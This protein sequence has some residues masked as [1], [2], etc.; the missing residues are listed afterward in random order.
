MKKDCSK[1]ATQREKKG[2]LWSR[3]PS[4]AERFI[5]VGDGNKVAVEAIETFRLLLKTGFHLDFVE[6]F[7]ASSIRRNLIS[8]SILDKSGYTCSFGNNKF[9]LSYDSNVVGYGSLNDNL[10]ML[11]IECPYNKIMQVESHGTKRKLNENSA[12]LWHKRLGHISKQRIQRLMSDEFGGEGNIRSVV[13]DEETI[14]DNDQ[15]FVPI[16][17]PETDPEINNDVIPN[18]P[19]EQDNAEFLPQAPPIVQTQQPQGLPL[20]RSTRERKCPISDDYVI[21]LQEHEDDIGLTEDDPINFSQA[22]RIFIG[23]SR[24][25]GCFILETSWLIVCLAQFWAVPRNVLKKA[26]SPATQSSNLFGD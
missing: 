7:V 6:T 11:D 14:T 9:S 26:Y 25:L 8:I 3:P 2:C 17:V 23:I 21:F 1:Y 5:Y 4:D 24:E 13:F 18:I 15:V 16:V 10:Y 22:M 12:T 20:R 19:Q